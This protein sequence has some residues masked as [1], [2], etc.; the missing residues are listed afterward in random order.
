MGFT[1][2][3]REAQASGVR[4]GNAPNRATTWHA[5]DALVR[6]RSYRVSVTYT[7]G[8]DV[9]TGGGSTTFTW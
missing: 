5:P 9:Q 7:V 4:Y 6:G 2:P 1:V 8:G 3:E